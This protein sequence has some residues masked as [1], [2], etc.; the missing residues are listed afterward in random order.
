[1]MVVS[2]R[3]MGAW[4]DQQL[5]DCLPSWLQD[6]VRTLPLALPPLADRPSQCTGYTKVAW[7]LYSLEMPAH[8]GVML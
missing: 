2:G 3:E 8:C 7:C 1:M 6:T 5:C 4:A